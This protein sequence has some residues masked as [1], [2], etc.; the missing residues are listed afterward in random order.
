M[1]L[2]YGVR[3][4]ATV[5]RAHRV[6]ARAAARAE[7]RRLLVASGCAR[8]SDWTLIL[9]PAMLQEET[10]TKDDTLTSAVAAHCRVARHGKSWAIGVSALLAFPAPLIGRCGDG[11]SKFGGMIYIAIYYECDTLLPRR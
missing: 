4:A 10:R 11:N 3:D 5:E 8:R 2:V 6:G 1:P 9:N 7:Q